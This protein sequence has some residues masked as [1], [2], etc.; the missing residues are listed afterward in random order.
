MTF[1][2]HIEGKFRAILSGLTVAL[3]MFLF[4]T[5]SFAQTPSSD[6]G[7]VPEDSVS[8]WAS[9]ATMHSIRQHRPTVALVLCGGGANGAAHV[10]VMEYLEKIGM[11]IDLV[12]GTSVGGLIGGF[13]SVGYTAEEIKE[14]VYGIDWDLALSDRIPADYISYSERKYKEKYMLSFP[15]YYR[16]DDFLS[17]RQE[18]LE[19]DRAQQHRY[20]DI[21]LGASEDN[22]ATKFFRDNILGSLPAGYAY[23]QNVN[24]I[25]SKLTVG[26]Q[27]SLRFENLPIPFVCVATDMVSSKAKLWYGGKLNSALRSTM[28]IP[29]VFAP[30]REDGMILVDGGMKNNYPTDVARSLGA[31]FIIG[32]DISSGYTSYSGINNILDIISQGVDMLGRDTYEKNVNDP[33][34]TVKPDLREFD[35]MSF[36]DANIR[37]MYGRG[38]DAA[39][40]QG[41]NLGV[42]KILVGPDTLRRRG[43]PAINITKDPVMVSEIRISGVDERESAYLMRKIHTE[44]PSKMNN[45]DIEDIVATIYGTKS[46]DYVTYELQGREEP[47]R[48]QINCERGPIHQVGIGARFDTEEIVAVLV[49]LGIN[50]HSIRGS[51]V[52]VTGKIGTNPY[53]RTQYYYR[54]TGGHTFNAALQYKYTDRN[55]FTVGKSNFKATYHNLRAEMFLSNINWKKFDL[56]IG[57]RNDFFHINSLMADR[58]LAD[59]DPSALHNSYVSAFLK[60]RMDNLD[61][62]YFPTKGISMGVD[63][64]WVVGA[65]QK[66]IDPFHAV[67]FDLRTVSSPSARFSVVHSLDGRFLFGGSIPIPYINTIG[68]TMAGRYLEQQI[69]F[70]GVGN[71]ATTGDI[72]LLLRQE[73]RYRIMK[74]NYVSAIVNVGDTLPSFNDVTTFDKHDI[75][76]GAGL[77]YSYNTIIGPLSAQLHWSNVTRKVGAYF[78][79]GFDF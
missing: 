65:L 17:R 34:V 64:Q 31:D 42:M 2:H 16:R 3:L 14:I 37:T 20:G 29:G 79:L 21:H 74:N 52:D 62:G 57:V 19:Y 73:F 50:V 25:F 58:V 32:I 10:G 30:V 72:L 39:L 56:A 26:Y 63:Y 69:P 22:D 49:N 43:H 28:S 38:I 51:S 8:V 45:E 6:E 41:D 4:Q 33:E 36:S 68:G 23:G 59:Y 78:S 47:F 67:Q 13:Y 35:M 46:F 48:L 66:E 55:Q 71:A 76:V 15:F 7:E 5:P 11:P 61:N 18:A 54:A 44:F 53:I 27:D 1:V 77:R 60:A 40:E 70:I 24:N 9:R 75:L 12:V